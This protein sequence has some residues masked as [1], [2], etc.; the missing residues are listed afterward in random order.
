MALVPSAAEPAP[1]ARELHDG[2]EL[3]VAGVKVVHTPGHT[4]GHV[5][6]LWPAHG[7]VLFVGDAAADLLG[8]LSLPTSFEDLARVKQSLGKIAELDFEHAVFGHGTPIKG[9]ANARFR[10]LVEQ[11]AG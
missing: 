2:D 1:V 9:K 3:P 5:S 10:R 8:R 7:G 4:P 6:F 11:Q